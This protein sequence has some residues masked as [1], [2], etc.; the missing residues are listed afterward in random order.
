MSLHGTHQKIF[1]DY[2]FEGVYI[3]T[4]NWFFGHITMGGL[5]LCDEL[6]DEEFNV[7]D[8]GCLIISG[9]DLL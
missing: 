3:E 1:L 4:S 5:R 7:D 8:N 6:S 9:V 2:C